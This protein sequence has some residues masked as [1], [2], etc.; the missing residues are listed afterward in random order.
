MFCIF[1]G[2]LNG[3]AYQVFQGKLVVAFGL[4]EAFKVSVVLLAVA[5]LVAGCSA[6][7]T[8]S[9]KI[10]SYGV[11]K[12]LP[13]LR[14]EG[15]WIVDEYGNRVALRGGG[16][17]YTAYDDWAML[18]KF[19]QQIKSIGGNCYR[20]AFNPPWRPGDKWED[21][22]TQYDPE[23]MDRT[24]DLCEKYGL[25]AILDCHHWQGTGD[26]DEWQLLPNYKDYWIQTW[27]EIAQRYKDRSVVAGYE[28]C[29]EAWGYTDMALE[30]MAAMRQV[31]PKHIFFLIESGYTESQWHQHDYWGGR[32]TWDPGKIE[33]YFGG[34]PP[35]YVLTTHHW[36]GDAYVSAGGQRPYDPADFEMGYCAS[37]L[38]TNGL[39]HIREE[40]NCPVILGEFGV[41]DYDMANMDAEHVRDI[42]RNLEDLGIGWWFWMMEKLVRDN[43]LH[44]YDLLQRTFESSYY[45]SDIPRAFKPKPFNLWDRVVNYGPRTFDWSY[46]E[47][48][49]VYHQIRQDSWIEVQGPCTLRIREWSGTIWWGVLESEYLLSIPEGSTQRIQGGLMEVFSHKSTS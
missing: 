15:Q 1:V 23:K 37:S 3:K 47:H 16:G 42:I 8:N 36:F 6:Q 32:R 34:N 10:G 43:G 17:S 14:V 25:Y 19:M 44:M 41:Y 24:L 18:E 33:A 26:P 49:V 30:C 2:R 27:V 31:D 28:L 9:W 39:R 7:I 46:T 22:M 12:R 5:V 4:R 29:N 21:K 45:S 13:W 40:M 20:L 11:V 35:Q 48:D 38:I